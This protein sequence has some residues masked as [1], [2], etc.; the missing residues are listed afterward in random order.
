MAKDVMKEAPRSIDLPAVKVRQPLGDFYVASIDFKTLCEITRADVRRMI[1]ERPFETYLGIQRPLVASRV[2]E[3]EKYVKTFDACFPTSIVLAID[4]KCAEFDERKQI[5]RLKNFV[6]TTSKDEILYIQI[7]RVLDGQHRI[8]GL[9]DYPGETFDL[10][11]SIFVDIDVE[12]QAYI[13][14]TVNLTQTKVSRSLAYDLFELAKTRSPQKTCHHVAVGLDQTK[15]SPFYKRI[16]RLGSAT[17]GRTGETITQATFVEALLPYITAD[18]M[19]DRD[20]YLRGRRPAKVD[21][22]SLRKHPFRNMFIEERDLEIADVVW[23]YFDAVRDKWP[24]AWNS[25]AQG[26]MLNKTNGFK[27]LMRLLHPAYLYVTEPGAVVKKEEFAKRIF[28]K[29]KLKDDEFDVETFKPGTSG[30]ALLFETLRAQ[31][32]LGSVKTA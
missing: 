12:D 3:L 15:K 27:A 20:L 24:S 22:V 11:V 2:R 18:A 25:G 9:K 6:D 4:G 14:S 7:A 23:N 16:K 28:A 5:L 17:V 29:V 32:G 30:E 13:F 26:L 1:E 19:I 10:S 8:E 31:A 21:D